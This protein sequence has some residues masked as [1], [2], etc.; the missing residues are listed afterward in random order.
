VDKDTKLRYFIGGAVVVLIIGAAAYKN[1]TKLPSCQVDPAGKI[2]I[3]IDQTDPVSTL[4]NVEMKRRVLD[5]LG[6]NRAKDERLKSDS[7]LD[8]P[9]NSLVSLFYIGSNQKDLNPIFSECRPPSEREVNALEGDPKQAQRR[10][11]DKFESK[12]APLVEIGRNKEKASPIIESLY[13]ISRTNFFSSLGK[14]KPRTKV[15]IFSDMVQHSDEI[16]LYGCSTTPNLSPSS[17][18]LMNKLSSAYSGADIVVNLIVR[19]KSDS[20]QLPS[21]QC[22]K[23]FWANALGGSVVIEEL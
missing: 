3:L 21:S 14:G 15:L 5:F 12:I 9:V 6:N 13:A 18:N 17:I 4:Q 2:V 22:L 8:T 11:V 7:I 20:Q 23:Q 1:I 19:D 10:Y 16:S